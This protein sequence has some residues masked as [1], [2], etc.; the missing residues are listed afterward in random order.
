MVDVGIFLDSYIMVYLSL[1]FLFVISGG[2]LNRFFFQRKRRNPQ[3]LQLYRRS[4]IS[5]LVLYLYEL[6]YSDE[7][8]KYL[9]HIDTSVPIFLALKLLFACWNLLGYILLYLHYL[10]IPLIYKFFVRF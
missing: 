3:F 2:N 1:K 5:L 6:N 7:Y 4:K 10:Y 8:N 9:I